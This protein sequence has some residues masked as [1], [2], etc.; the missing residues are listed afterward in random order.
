[1]LRFYSLLLALLCFSPL[2]FAESDS[3]PVNEKDGDGSIIEIK[4]RGIIGVDNR[5]STD[6]IPDYIGKYKL[7]VGQLI[8]RYPSRDG[9][10]FKES[11]CTGSLIARNYIVTAAHCAINSDGSIHV[12]QFFYP[13]I[14]SYGQS[15]YEKYKV[16]RIYMPAEY[17]YKSDGVH[18]DVDIAIMELEKSSKDK[19]PGQVVGTFGFWGKSDFSEGD[20]TTIGYPGD[21][22]TSRQYYQ[23]GCSASLD[24][25]DDRVILMNCD[26]F[27]G[28]SGSPVLIYS[29]KYDTFHIQGVVSAE[30]PRINV[31]SRISLERGRIFKHI[32]NGQFGSSDYLAN[33]FLE[34]WIDIEA[35]SVDEVHVFAKNTCQRNDLYI[36]Y[37]YK[38]DQ[39][40]WESDGYFKIS[41]LQDVE[42]FNTSNRIYYIEAR[43][44]DG[45]I[46]TKSELTK[47]VPSIDRKTSLQKYKVDSYGSFTYEFG[48]Y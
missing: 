45:D 44:R 33:S 9:R 32:I 20:M 30:S 13:G 16:S 19:Y 14:N 15:P 3:L 39:G 11:Q 27:Q 10:G 7:R 21:K 34:N 31:G 47:Y 18:P 28:Q 29:E 41:P 17:Y 6:S 23:S 36:A 42:I 12:N 25:E 1:M 2:V 37:N 46:F 8:S 26:V 22:E 5:K 35:P 38:N 40:D 43:N 4:D 24:S 48:C